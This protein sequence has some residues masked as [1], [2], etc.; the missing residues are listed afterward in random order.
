M[1][2]RNCA[3]I[4]APF[5]YLDQIAGDIWGQS[6]KNVLLAIWSIWS[7]VLVERANP[8]RPDEPDRPV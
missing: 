1:E 7:V 3:A 8:D 2:T 4:L 5:R 6:R